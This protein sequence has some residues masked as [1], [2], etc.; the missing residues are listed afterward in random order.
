MQQSGFPATWAAVPARDRRIYNVCHWE[1]GVFCFDLDSDFAMLVLRAA[2]VLVVSP[3]LLCAGDANPRVRVSKKTTYVT[4]PLRKDGRVDYIAALNRRYGRGVTAGNNAAVLF[5]RAVGPGA[6]PQ[7]VRAKLFTG[8]EMKP[9]P[10]KGSYFVPLSALTAG[11]QGR[12]KR[13]AEADLQFDFDAA[14]ERPWKT[15]QYPEVAKWLASNAAP[16]KLLVKAAE[17]PQF[18]TPL[19][20]PRKS[21]ASLSDTLGVLIATSSRART[22][23]RM[24][25]V[26]AN[27][28]LADGQPRDAM[29]D[30]LAAHRWARLIDRQPFLIGGM[31]APSIE[32]AAGRGDW[33]LADSKHLT[34]ADALAYRKQLEKLG[35]LWRLPEKFGFSERC[36]TLDGMASLSRR[37]GAAVADALPAD[38]ARKLKALLKDKDAPRLGR[39]I[40]WNAVAERVNRRFDGIA[41]VAAMTDL[42]A[43]RIAARKFAAALGSEESCAQRFVRAL[44]QKPADRA[45]VAD[46]LADSLVHADVEMLPAT[47][48]T[49]AH[50]QV[51][52]DL[53]RVMFALAAYRRDHGA[54]PGKLT[55]LGPQYLPRAVP[56][57]FTGKPLQYALRKRG[58][59]LYSVGAN[60]RDDG[61]EVKP[62]ASDDVVLRMFR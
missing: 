21:G 26:R 42:R 5:W 10:E 27:R 3:V 32:K 29:R 51:R 62:P 2:V 53:A 1:A 36:F 50:T 33:I 15:F 20:S 13:Q 30:L 28:S 18:F 4:K 60:G 11:L 56:D 38:S 35:P 17:R 8:L 58:Y 12:A 37:G 45:R 55:A 46:A 44:K 31:S 43:R 48:D 23:T 49:H 41:G 47:L 40:D 19:V 34:A 61:G 39:V 52:F 24:L 22:T 54:Y 14:L 16:L 25:L 9:L 6:I 7:G 57:R 59:V